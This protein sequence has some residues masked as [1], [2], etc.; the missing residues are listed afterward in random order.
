MKIIVFFFL[1]FSVFSTN[2]SQARSPHYN[3]SVTDVDTKN[4]A[5]KNSI[6]NSNDLTDDIVDEIANTDDDNN[7]TY[8]KKSSVDKSEKTFT[9]FTN[10]RI[11]KNCK[12]VVSFYTYHFQVSI[13]I[14]IFIKQ[15]RI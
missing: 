6:N 9:C 1:I 8:N 3:L 2:T 15:Y 10:Y 5:K 4:V 14:I 7:D 12:S 11:L 13:A